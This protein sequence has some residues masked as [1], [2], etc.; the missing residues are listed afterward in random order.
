VYDAVRNAAQRQYG[1]RLKG[2]RLGQTSQTRGDPAA[3]KLRKIPRLRNCTAR[4]HGQD[5]FAIRRMDAERVTARAPVPAKS[6]REK[7]GAVPDDKSRRF[8]R[9]PIEER[10]SSHVCESG[11]EQFPRILPY[12]S[13]RK[14]LGAKTNHLPNIQ[15][16]RHRQTPLNGPGTPLLAVNRAWEHASRIEVILIPSG[17]RIGSNPESNS[18]VAG[19]LR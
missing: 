5:R 1:A 12:P 15:G 6:Y 11:E 19:G 18:E 2:R 14:S 9:P 13:P 16:A 8:V 7:L 3:M 10:A 4:R 17:N